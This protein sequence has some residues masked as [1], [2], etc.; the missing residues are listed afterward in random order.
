[1]ADFQQGIL[2]FYSVWLVFAGFQPR[3]CLKRR[4]QGK[5][6]PEMGSALSKQGATVWSAAG[7]HLCGPAG[8]LV[9]CC[10]TEVGGARVM[11]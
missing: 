11:T 8:L 4:D 1:M 3:T 5:P 2:D 9:G 7:T 6:R 10:G